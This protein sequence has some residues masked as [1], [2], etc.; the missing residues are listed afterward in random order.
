MPTRDADHYAT[1]GASAD[2]G[3]VKIAIAHIDQGLFPTA[4]CKILPDIA[5]D[6]DFCTIIHS[7]SAGTKSSLAYM[8]L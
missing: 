8:V 1:L 3:D 6:R 2:K 4:F 5:S 7:D